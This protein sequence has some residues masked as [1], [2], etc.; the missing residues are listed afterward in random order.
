MSWSSGR[1]LNVDPIEDQSEEDLH[2]FRNMLHDPNM[3][4]LVSS[5]ILAFGLLSLAVY[6][7]EVRALSNLLCY[8]FI[9]HLAATSNLI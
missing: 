5:E 2:I 8:M 3:N 1:K 9:R 4:R 6:N 7:L